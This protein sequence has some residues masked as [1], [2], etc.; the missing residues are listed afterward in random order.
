MMRIQRTSRQLRF[1]CAI[2]C[3]TVLLACGF[4]VALSSP[5][6]AQQKQRFENW[7]AFEA[8]AALKAYRSELAAGGGFTDRHRQLLVDDGLAQLMMDANRDR[9]ASIRARLPAVLLGKIT[10]AAA[11]GEASTAAVEALDQLARRAKGTVEGSVNACLLLGELQTQEGQLLA[12]ATPVLCEL[13]LDAAVTPAVR[14]AALVGIRGRVEAAGGGST[15]EIKQAAV[16][17]LPTVERLLQLDEPPAAA[18]TVLIDWLQQ[19]TL[20]LAVKLVPLAAADPQPLAAVGTAALTLLQNAGKP[21]NLRVRAAALLAR[22]VKADEATRAAEIVDLIEA[23][24]VAAVVEDREALALIKLERSLSGLD[25]QAGGPPGM[26]AESMMIGPN[27]ESLPAVPS[28]LPGPRCL[29]TS[30]RLGSLAEALAAIATAQDDAGKPY[31]QRAG[32]LRD[33][34]LAIYKDPG[35][36]TVLA[37]ADAVDPQ[38][39]ASDTDAAA[40][41][42]GMVKPPAP[43][44]GRPPSEP[45]PNTP[46]SPFQ[47]R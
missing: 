43:T 4:F 3:A 45:R 6:A 17:L 32:K 33:L 22:L 24:A 14:V 40:N 19:R 18:T 30:W 5:A 1:K 38:P 29:Q 12:A 41:P 35:D 8:S 39:E 44:G 42:A 16:G 28:L 20:D 23:V 7:P 10:N 15:P 25:S 47:I 21:V 9:L 26:M 36:K 11:Y 34:G 13:T 37:A 31:E 27:G 46:F 2:A